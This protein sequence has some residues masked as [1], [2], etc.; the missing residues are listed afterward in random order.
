MTE[1]FE[2][3]LDAHPGI[4]P[5]PRGESHH[6][7][8]YVG[9]DEAEALSKLLID[10]R[11]YSIHGGKISEL[12]RH[13]LSYYVPPL[14][15]LLDEGYRP[16]AEL[17]RADIE[18]SGIGQTVAQIKDYYDTKGLELRMLL[19]VG[20]VDKAFEHYEAVVSFVRAR[21]GVWASLLMR[22]LREHPE[23]ASFRDAVR[24]MGPVEEA[25]LRIIEEGEA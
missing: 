13:A 3:W 20:E 19:D 24:R 15:M 21:S 2:A 8:V 9:R 17:M 5:K 12:V 18:R 16:L 14:L 23:L 4:P 10:H 7:S 22:M 25:R 6:I 11:L 1:S